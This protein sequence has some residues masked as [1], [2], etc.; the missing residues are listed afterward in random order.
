MKSPPKKMDSASRR[1]SRVSL[2]VSR[3]CAPARR[4]S[5]L[6]RSTRSSTNTQG[7]LSSVERTMAA[8]N[9]TANMVVAVKAQRVAGV[10]R[11]AAKHAVARVGGLKA[12]VSVS[13]RKG[14]CERTRAAASFLSFAPR[15]IELS[16]RAAPEA[17]LGGRIRRARASP[18]NLKWLGLPSRIPQ[19]LTSSV[20][21]LLPPRAQA[22]DRAWVFSRPAS[23]SRSSSPPSRTKRW[24]GPPRWCVPGAFVARL[25]EIAREPKPSNLKKCG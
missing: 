16:A 14:T 9:V 8:L 12:P 23:T 20:P 22:A 3:A 15:G 21:V 13:M 2:T 18:E 25:S 4:H 17:S 11:V 24:S 6:T 1:I 19:S 5:R 7:R 10:R